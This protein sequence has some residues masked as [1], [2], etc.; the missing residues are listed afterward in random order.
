MFKQ[1]YI[2][3]KP[4]EI[5]NSAIYNFIGNS[6]RFYLSSMIRYFSKSKHFGGWPRGWYILSYFV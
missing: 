1:S 5:L 6:D 2:T 3:H 4:K